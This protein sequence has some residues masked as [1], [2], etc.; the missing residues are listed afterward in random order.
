MFA[1]TVMTLLKV[2]GGATPPFV[3]RCEVRDLACFDEQVDAGDRRRVVAQQ[4]RHAL[5]DL[6]GL[7]Q[8][9]ERR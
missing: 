4:E 1:A 3:V 6:L 5:A 7:D 9:A 8:A 2:R